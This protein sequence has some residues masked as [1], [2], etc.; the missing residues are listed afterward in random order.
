VAVAAPGFRVIA[1]AT[2]VLAW[3]LKRSAIARLQMYADQTIPAPDALLPLVGVQVSPIF[4]ANPDRVVV[5]GTPIISN[6]VLSTAEHTTSTEQVLLELVCR[7][8]QPGDADVDA[9]DVDRT[10]GYLVEAVA[11]ALLDF[12][13]IVDRQF[14]TISLS[15][16]QQALTAVVSNPEP[17]VTASAS[18]MFTADM[19]T[20]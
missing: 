18:I 3:P 15:R 17:S 19:V 14:G 8:F 4:P 10:L 5:Y 12:E 2:R 1:V 7:V 6:R 9:I 13:P 20:T 16:V 11:A